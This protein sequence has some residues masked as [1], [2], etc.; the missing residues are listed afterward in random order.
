MKWKNIFSDKKDDENIEIEYYSKDKKEQDSDSK[1]TKIKNWFTANDSYSEDDFE[2][3]DELYFD[4]NE[5]YQESS[6]NKKSKKD[7]YEYHEDD[8][9]LDVVEDDFEEFEIEYTDEL[10]SNNKIEKTTDSKMAKFKNLF[11]SNDKYEEELDFD[12]DYEYDI[13]EEKSSSKSSKFKNLFTSKNKHE[14]ELDFDKEDEETI[15]KN[16]SFSKK[17]DKENNNGSFLDKIKNIFKTEEFESYE[18]KENRVW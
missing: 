1:L 5:N 10:K 7:N 4:D 8:N 14:E 11:T 17:Q 2:F 12:E 6:N 16:T 18:E 9:Y 3:E 15:S 13:E